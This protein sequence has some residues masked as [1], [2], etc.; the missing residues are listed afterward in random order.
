M[1]FPS[2]IKMKLVHQPYRPL[3]L[4]Q[5]EFLRIFS[6][7]FPLVKYT[8][9][10][11]VNEMDQVSLKLELSAPSEAFGPLTIWVYESEIIVATKRD[12]RHFETNWYGAHEAQIRRKVRKTCYYAIDY[13]NAFMNGSIIVEEYRIGAKVSKVYQYHKNKPHEPIAATI[14]LAGPMK[15]SWLTWVKTK[16]G[17]QNKPVVTIKKYDWF[18]EIEE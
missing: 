1:Y 10:Q 12:H 7:A 11:E 8:L 15:V 16:L 14:G 17:L 18:G 2:D 6:K 13:I 5:R 4:L 3:F 9:I